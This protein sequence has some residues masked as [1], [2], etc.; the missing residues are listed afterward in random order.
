[1][2]IQKSITT[3]EVPFNG[4]TFLLDVAEGKLMSLNTIYEATS[5]PSGKDDPRQWLRQAQT[6]TL[7]LT[8]ICEVN[9]KAG[10]AEHLGNRPEKE[11]KSADLEAWCG[12]AVEI[13]VAAGVL[14]TK[15]GRRGG[16]TWAHWKIAVKYAGYL[17][18]ALDSA[19]LDVFRERVQEELNPELALS[20]GRE[21]AIAGWR[22]QGQTDLWIEQRCKTVDSWHGWTDTLKAHGVEGIGYAKCADSINVPILGGTAKE[23]RQSRQIATTSLRDSLSDVEN[24]AIN[25]A[26]V[27]SRNDIQ[28]HQLNGNRPCAKACF[29]ASTKVAKV[30]SP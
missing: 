15:R 9:P 13:G 21:R 11:T 1:M 12:K 30:I 20:R 28:Q 19:I 29:D 16:G 18:P 2:T 26:Q 27:L 22:R 14:K 17:M 8:I 10:A 23:V 24:A 7:L 6:A 3:I 5:T 25:L 4:A